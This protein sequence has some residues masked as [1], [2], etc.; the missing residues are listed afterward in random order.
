MHLKNEARGESPGSE[1]PQ[2]SF[3]QPPKISLKLDF[4]SLLDEEDVPRPSPP[5]PDPQIA[6]DAPEE[7]ELVAGIPPTVAECR[8]FPSI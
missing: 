7:G 6:S 4:G 5:S 1:R 2:V 8:E 3:D